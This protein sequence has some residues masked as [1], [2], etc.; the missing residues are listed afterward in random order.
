MLWRTQFNIAHANECCIETQRECFDQIHG[1]TAER[2]RTGL[3]QLQDDSLDSI[4]NQVQNGVQRSQNHFIHFPFLDPL[5]ITSVNITLN[6][7]LAWPAATCRTLTRH[8]W[9]HKVWCILRLNP[10]D[11]LLFLRSKGQFV[12]AIWTT[13]FR[14]NHPGHRCICGQD[15][16]ALKWI[17][18]YEG[19]QQVQTARAFIAIEKHNFQSWEDNWLRVKK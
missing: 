16:D 13:L 10:S 17:K 15:V 5:R 8:I 3:M 14:F 11:L 18:T 7:S 2:R 1:E 19:T 6:C 12:S 4:L 9:K